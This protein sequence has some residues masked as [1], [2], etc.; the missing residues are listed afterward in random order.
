MN[1]YFSNVYIANLIKNVSIAYEVKPEYRKDSNNKYRVSK[2]N[3]ISNIIMNLDFDVYRNLPL[4]IKGIGKNT[5][6]YLQELFE[7]GKVTHYEQILQGIP[8][9]LFTLARSM[10]AIKAYKLIEKYNVTTLEQLQQFETIELKPQLYLLPKMITISNKLKDYIVQDIHVKRTEV[11]GSIRRRKAMIKD[12]DIVIETTDLKKTRDYVLRY[13]NIHEVINQGDNWLIVKLKINLI[14]VDIRLVTKQSKEYIALLHHLTG[15]KFHNIKLREFAKKSGF[16]INEHGI[17]K[18]KIQFCPETEQQFFEY[19]GFPYIPP[20]LREYGSELTQEIPK[21]LVTLEDIKGDLH[22]HS[23]FK[24]QSSHDYGDSSIDQ[25]AKAAVNLG[26]KYFGVSDHNPKQ[27]LEASEMIKLLTQRKKEITKASKQHNI[28]IYNILE[29]DIRPDGTLAITDD[30]LETLDF[31][32]VS[33][34]SSF[35]LDIDTMTDR[36]LRG[37]SHPKAKILGHGTCR[38]IPDIRKEI[39]VHWKTIFEFCVNNDKYLEINAAP[40]RTDLP[41]NLILDALSF[42]VK[43]VINSDT[44]LINQLDN[45][46]YGVFN[47][48]KGWCSKEDIAN[49]NEIFQ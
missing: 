30:V 7:T 32:I 42:G 8:E 22:I 25:L 43:F 31:V 37:M 44:H 4:N 18:N 35:D 26:Y 48:R 46:I 29:V 41:C 1:Y 27:S 19:L 10:P 34:H 49:A 36:I 14:S 38:I 6:A 17:F 47:A 5:E 21:Q 24:I 16:M 33:I 11:A 9:L 23:S 12:I 13:E 3:E 15:S 45:M 28:R 40:P 20:E 2:L 39:R